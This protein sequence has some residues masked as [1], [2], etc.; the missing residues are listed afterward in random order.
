MKGNSPNKNLTKSVWQYIKKP[1]ACNR[2]VFLKKWKYSEER[3]QNL[4]G[5]CNIYNWQKF[6]I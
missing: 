5:I 6:S 1:N 4:E 2:D 3:S